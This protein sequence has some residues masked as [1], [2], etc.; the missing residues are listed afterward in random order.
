MRGFLVAFANFS[1]FAEVASRSILKGPLVFN[2]QAA[3][4]PFHQLRGRPSMIR[5]DV[6]RSA[7]SV[8]RGSS[9]DRP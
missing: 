7:D 3:F 9:R 8:F 4:S 2:K 5:V 6:E 1:V